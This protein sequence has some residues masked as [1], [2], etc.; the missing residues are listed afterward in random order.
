MERSK[1]KDVPL[2]ILK[3]LMTLMMV[4]LMGIRSDFISSNTMPRTE[5]NTMQTSSWFHLK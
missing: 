2:A 5:R 4:G 1:R 3:T